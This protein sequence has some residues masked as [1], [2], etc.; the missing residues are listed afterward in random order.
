MVTSYAFTGTF[1][2]VHDVVVDTHDSGDPPTTGVNVNARG[3]ALL[4][5]PR[6][7]SAASCS[8]A[9]RVTAAVPADP[10]G[11]TA[12]LADEG[13]T[14]AFSSD[15]TRLLVPLLDKTSEFELLK[16]TEIA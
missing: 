8:D 1:G 12:G 7:P 13:V 16:V 6:L 4:M 10:T 5:S 15:T 11:T 3:L 9:E 14:D 2:K